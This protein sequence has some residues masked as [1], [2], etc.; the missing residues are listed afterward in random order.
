MEVTLDEAKTY[1]RVASIDEDELITSII[2]SATKLVQDVSRISDEDWETADSAVIRI[3]ILYT[4]AYLYE[5]REEADHS[6]L[7]LTLRA[8]LFGVREE[9]F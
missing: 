4:I 1:L 6:Q 8:L 7:N 2:G 9:G 5:H 3:A